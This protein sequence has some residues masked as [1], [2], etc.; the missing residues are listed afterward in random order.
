MCAAPIVKNFLE[1]MEVAQ[2][3]YV[4]G[5]FYQSARLYN[6]QFSVPL[7]CLTT[8]VG[9]AIATNQQLFVLQFDHAQPNAK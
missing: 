5:L 1:L 9:P 6:V 2:H 7:R 8:V 3:V 4:M